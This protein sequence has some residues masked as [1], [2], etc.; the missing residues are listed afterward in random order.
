[1]KTK[2]DRAFAHSIKKN[3]S[4]EVL[5]PN[6]L[7]GFGI[8]LPFRSQGFQQNQRSTGK[9]HSLKINKR[10]FTKLYIWVQG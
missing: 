3:G 4:E 6:F 8:K 2:E 9:G 7:E 10:C 1:M 5:Q